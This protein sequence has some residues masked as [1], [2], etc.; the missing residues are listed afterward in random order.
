MKAVTIIT[1]KNILGE[2][3]KYICVNDVKVCMVSKISNP[4]NS[5]YGVREKFFVS[6]ITN[7]LG[8]KWWARTARTLKD[9][10]VYL[11]K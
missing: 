2:D 1:E 8:L 9:V 3:V 4:K 6:N 7:E 10:T 5:G 11:A